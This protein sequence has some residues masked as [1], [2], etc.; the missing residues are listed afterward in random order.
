VDCDAGDI[1]GNKDD[2]L[3]LVL[4]GIVG[5]GLTKD[6][7]DL[8]TGVANARGPPFLSHQSVFKN[9]GKGIGG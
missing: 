9:Y 6:N 2:G 8:A 5:V 3:L 7:E 4:V 1:V